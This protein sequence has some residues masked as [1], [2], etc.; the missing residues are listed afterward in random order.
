MADEKQM[1]MKHAAIHQ[2]VVDLEAAIIVL[3]N[4]KGRV[5]GEGADR[6]EVE[7]I[8]PATPTLAAFLDGTPGHLGRLTERV[9]IAEKELRE[10]L[11]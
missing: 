3:E 8:D 10:M 5:A 2:E 11:Y 7:P 1:M 4:L 6:K 9:A